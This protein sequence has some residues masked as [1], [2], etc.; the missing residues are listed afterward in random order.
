MVDLNGKPIRNSNSLL[1]ECQESFEFHFVDVDE[2]TE[3]ERSV[4]IMTG[5]ILAMIDGQPKNVKKNLVSETMSVDQDSFSECSGLWEP[6]KKR[7]LIKRD[8]LCNLEMYS[9]TFLHEIAHAI[10]GAGDTTRVRAGTHEDIGGDY[11]KV[12][13]FVKLTYYSCNHP[14]WDKHHI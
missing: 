9:G 3:T 5:K 8:Q 11:L 13:E 12:I 14:P 10:S 2:L 6:S 4:F 1:M 7:I